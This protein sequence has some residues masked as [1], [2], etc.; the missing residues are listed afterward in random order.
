MKPQLLPHFLSRR[1]PRNFAG[2]RSPLTSY[3]VP[4][5]PYRTTP[6][7]WNTAKSFIPPS[8]RRRG[9]LLLCFLAHIRSKDDFSYFPA[10]F[11]DRGPVDRARGRFLVTGVH[12]AYYYVFTA[13]GSVL[14]S[15][16]STGPETSLG[17]IEGKTCEDRW[18]SRMVEA[19]HHD[20]DAPCPPRGT[21]PRTLK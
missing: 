18:S 1:W 20:H 19:I 8:Q 7:A 15:R 21:S 12:T 14:A 4:K 9:P 5:V 17:P 2:V 13:G 16:Q 3:Y 6:A 11:S 10:C